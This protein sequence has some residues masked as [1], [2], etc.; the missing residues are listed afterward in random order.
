MDFTISKYRGSQQGIAQIRAEF[1]FSS[2]QWRSQ[3]GGGP[4]HLTSLGLRQFGKL[5]VKNVHIKPIKGKIVIS[6]YR[7]DK[8]KYL[9]KS[10]LFVKC[11]FQIFIKI[12]INTLK[13]F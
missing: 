8:F 1:K 4:G 5:Y 10:Q 6:N 12:Y 11:F 9:V 3:E 7:A 13:I 2:K